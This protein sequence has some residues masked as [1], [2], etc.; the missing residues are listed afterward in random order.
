MQI[1][2]L[3]LFI[4]NPYIKIPW[5]IVLTFYLTNPNTPIKG[6]S[7]FYN[8]IN[9][10]SIY[11]KAPSMKTWELDL[12]SS[13]TP[14]QWQSSLTSTYTA[15]K[16]ANLWELSQ[17]ILLRWYLSPTRIAGLDPRTSLLCWIQC[18]HRG[19]LFHIL[20]TCPLLST[21]WWD[22]F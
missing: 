3:L 16:S 8:F 9:Q 13:F 10:K 12:M 7:L 4:T 22:V 11:I 5:R 14:K 15:S 2:H 21:F 6:V 18:G 17:K 19:W 20:W 1:T